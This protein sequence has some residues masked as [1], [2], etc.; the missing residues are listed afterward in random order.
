M[1]GWTQ[2][3]VGI[4]YTHSTDTYVTLFS[5]YS[6]PVEL[7]RLED[8]KNADQTMDNWC[9]RAKNRPIWIQKRQ[10]V[11]SH[12]QNLYGWRVL[13]NHWVSRCEL[14]SNYQ[15]HVGT[16]SKFFWNYDLFMVIW[17]KHKIQIILTFEWNLSS[18]LYGIFLGSRDFLHYTVVVIGRG[19]FLCVH[20]PHKKRM[21][22]AFKA[23]EKAFNGNWKA[24]KMLVLRILT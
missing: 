20:T 7:C 8:G 9:N 21:K 11:D 5:T 12:T 17:N 14:S 13:N 22:T 2:N 10:V 6:A 4:T 18:F 3:R 1:S 19:S 15:I 23:Q 24:F 16:V